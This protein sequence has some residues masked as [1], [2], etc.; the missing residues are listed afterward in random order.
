M[1]NA[2]TSPSLCNRIAGHAVAVCVP[3]HLTTPATPLMEAHQA[4]YS[5]TGNVFK[6]LKNIADNF[7]CIILFNTPAMPMVPP[8][9]KHKLAGF[10]FL[11]RCS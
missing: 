5:F 11:A 1:M 4:G 10:S 9:A 6:L 7:V 8:G 3:F 2:Y